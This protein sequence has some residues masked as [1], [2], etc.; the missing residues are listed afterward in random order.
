MTDTPQLTHERVA[1]IA[2]LHEDFL[3]QLESLAIEAIATGEWEAV[4]DHISLNAPE[5]EET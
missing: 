3:N 1:E 4:Y 5:R 2:Q